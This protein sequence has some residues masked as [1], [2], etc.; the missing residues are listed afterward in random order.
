MTNF[1]S[2]TQLRNLSR[3][4]QDY[5][6]PAHLLGILHNSESQPIT[7]SQNG[8]TQSSTLQ[9]LRNERSDL[10]PSSN[11]QVDSSTIGE[12]T[13]WLS[14]QDELESLGLPKGLMLT[15]PPGTG[16]TTLA[17]LLT[18]EASTSNPFRFVELSATTATTTDV[19]KVFD[20]ALNRLQLNG[21][22]TVLFLD[23]IQRF[24]RAQQVSVKFNDSNEFLLS[25]LLSP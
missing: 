4:L 5:V 20:E 17:R 10:N 22:R 25:L 3:V 19:K 23:E 6:P 21:Q 9:K 13:K 12:L 8:Q 14:N 18:R 15:G 24:N 16:K 11:S 1:S 7:T 2:F